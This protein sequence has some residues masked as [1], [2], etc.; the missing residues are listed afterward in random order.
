MGSGAPGHVGAGVRMG[1]KAGGHGGS[2]R[3]DIRFG[4]LDRAPLAKIVMG[5][6][7]HAS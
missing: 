4:E 1:S 2:L 3:F 6:S 7:G 5:T